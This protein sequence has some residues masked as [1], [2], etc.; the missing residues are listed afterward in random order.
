ML[1]PELDRAFVVELTTDVTTVECKLKDKVLVWLLE[2]LLDGVVLD[3]VLEI[4]DVLEPDGVLE[5]VLE[6]VPEPEELTSE[7]ALD[8]CVVEW[9]LVWTWELED[10]KLEIDDVARWL[11]DELLDTV[12]AWLDV[13]TV[14]LPLEE[15]D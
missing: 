8:G 7:C 12:A 5:L 11:L 15:L 3:P 13:T 2:W 10:G 4:N 9:L 1:E 6:C 14:L